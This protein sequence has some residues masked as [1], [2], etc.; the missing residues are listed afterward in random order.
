MVMLLLFGQHAALSQTTP[1]RSLVSRYVAALQQR[2]YRTIVELYRNIRLGEAVIQVDNP[3]SLWPKLIA[4]YRERSVREL[5]G[6]EKPIDIGDEVNLKYVRAEIDEQLSFLPA[7]CKWAIAEIRADGDLSGHRFSTIFVTLTYTAR[8]NSP[9][10]AAGKPL[11]RAILQFTV[12]APDNSTVM[13][14]KQVVAGE[15]LWS[16][17]Q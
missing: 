16:N 14:D 11:Q 12:M 17:P 8:E 9:R 1:V 2:D 5:K 6:E 13:F 3:K 10:N 7:G 15:V 4:E